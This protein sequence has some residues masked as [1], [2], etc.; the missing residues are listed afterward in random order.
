[1]VGT[2]QSQMPEELAALVEE[3][4]RMLMLAFEQGYTCGLLMQ[5]SVTTA[6]V[7]RLDLIGELSDSTLANRMN[8]ITLSMI[9]MICIDMLSFGILDL[10]LDA[11]FDASTAV[12]L[13]VLMSM[14]VEP[15]TLS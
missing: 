12:V 9:N 8:V 14:Q 3:G 6:C 5:L 11:L 2:G 4:H 7:A 1:M 13:V 10:H 15:G